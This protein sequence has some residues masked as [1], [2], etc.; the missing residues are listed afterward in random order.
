MNYLKNRLPN[1]LFCT[2]ASLVLLSICSISQAREEMYSSLGQAKKT[3]NTALEIRQIA[4]NVEQ[5]EF[6]LS[7]TITQIAGKEDYITNGNILRI[8][9]EKKRKKEMHRKPK[10]G[11]D[12]DELMRS[13]YRFFSFTLEVENRSNQILRVAKFGASPLGVLIPKLEDELGAIKPNGGI[14]TLFSMTYNHEAIGAVTIL[15]RRTGELEIPFSLDREEDD[16]Y[17]ITLGYGVTRVIYVDLKPNR[18]YKISFT[19][20]NEIGSLG[21]SEHPE[22]KYPIWQGSSQISPIEF[23]FEP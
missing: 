10:P 16:S 13:E 23:S 5:P 6:R 12:Y 17:T 20:K 15:P 3:G 19:Y 2:A 22:I 7:R 1:W 18:K 11:I 8:P 9:P 14:E 21:T 4:S